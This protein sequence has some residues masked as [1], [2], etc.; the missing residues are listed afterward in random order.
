[1]SGLPITP[2]DF[3]YRS[4]NC[5]ITRRDHAKMHKRTMLAALAIAVSATNAD[6]QHRRYRGQ[7]VYRPAYVTA[8]SPTQSAPADDGGFVGW[9]NGIRGQHGLGP[10]ALDFDLCQWA[11][12][13]NGHQHTRGMGHHVMG[14]ARRQNSGWGPFSTVCSMWMA[15]HAHRAALLDPTISF[16][17]IAG[18][19]A[20]WTFNAR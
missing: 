5:S 4:R 1:M 14:S 10:V 2:N 12:A 11:A 15:S 20:Y 8:Q 3:P 7:T 18:S 19:G 13:N 16:V 6:A 9:L 17:G